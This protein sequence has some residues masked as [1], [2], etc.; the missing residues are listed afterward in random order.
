TAMTSANFDATGY[1]ILEKLPLETIKYLLS[2]GNDVNKLTHDARTYIFWAAYKSNI[3]LMDYL[4]EQGAKTDLVDQHGYSLFMFTAVTAQENEE[5]YEY[6]MKLGADP[7]KE[8]DREGR[9]ALL[10][11]A[12]A[13]KTGDMLDYFIDLGLDVNSVDE[14]GNGI[15]NQA[16][17]TGNQEL[18]ERLISQYKVDTNPNKKTNENAILFASRRFSRSGEET[19]ISYYKYLERLGLDPKVVSTSGNT[20]LQNLARRSNSAEL[21]NYFIDKGVNVD[22]VDDEGNNALINAASRKSQELIALLAENTTDINVKN[23]E[24]L[25]AFTRAL[26]YN[27]LEIAKYLVDRGA[28]TDISDRK[29]YD[30]GYHLVDAFRGDMESFKEKMDYLVSLGYDPLSVQKDGSTLLHAAVNKEHM[31]LVK[32]VAEM[33]I[34]INAKDESG[35][36][37]LHYAAMQADDLELLRLLVEAGA[38]KDITTEFDESAYD[39]A[40]TN[41]QLN[42]GDEDMDFLRV[43]GE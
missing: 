33:G 43:G 9:N 11:Y 34:D 16:A 40:L 6:I 18:L 8:R 28:D 42:A 10:A 39:L 30:L 31:E 26:K 14:D 21:Y 5:V 36:T 27:D 3:P 41:E 2:Q 22:Q 32:E 13:T 4:I 38:D 25:S 24:G 20:V 35:Q 17:K 1:A 23:K 7:M 19:S 29:G 15:F 12:S 37:V